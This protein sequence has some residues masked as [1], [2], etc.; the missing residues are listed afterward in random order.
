V[1]NERFQ[2]GQA[3]SL[4]AGLEAADPDTDA[5]VI[6]LGDQPE[7]RTEAIAAVVDAF[8]RDPVPVVQASYSGRPAHPIL[9]SRAA[10]PDL[11][12]LEGD[13]GAR[14]LLEARTWERRLVEVGGDP[15]EDIDTD[16]D[17]ERARSRLRQKR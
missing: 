13:R 11:Q 12:R 16:D 3:S 5:V 6:L 15:P 4:L 14:D 8:G 7:V 17:Y 1:V 9:F 10:W 2:T